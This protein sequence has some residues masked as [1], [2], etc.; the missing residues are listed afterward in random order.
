M[1]AL[2]GFPPLR[3]AAPTIIEVPYTILSHTADTGIAAVAPTIS[4]L[5]TELATG[6]FGLMATVANSPPHRSIEVAVRSATVED[7]IV[8]TL[9]ELLF[10]SEVDDLVFNNFDVEAT[11]T[12]AHVVAHGVDVRAAEPSGPPIKAVTYH[13]L[14]VRRSGDT[15]EAT[16]YF[17]V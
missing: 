7:L 17:D 6:M 9:S 16:V 4:E 3:A 11:E 12:S 10:R 8:D 1:R 14:A 13:D 2:T 15:W 5:L